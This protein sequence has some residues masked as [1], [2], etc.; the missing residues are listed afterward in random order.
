MNT[1][2]MNR[3]ILT[4]LAV[5]GS[6]MA[7]AQ[8]VHFSQM[9]Y[10]PLTLN[11]ALAGANSPL[12]VILNYR[13]QW[14]S[15]ASPYKTMAAS[16]DGRINDNKRGKK[17]N[18]AYGVNF[19]NDQAGDARV[20]TTNV[21]ATLGY[22]I[23][24]DRTSTLGAA[25]C[26]GFGQRS[27]DPNSGR[28]GSQY[29][30]MAYDPTL[31]SGETF[32]TDR[33]AFGDFGAGIVY[34]YK[35]GD[36][37]MT[38]NDQ[39]SFNY[40]FALYHINKPKYSYLGAAEEELYMRWSMFANGNIGLGNSRWSI[41]P[42]VYYQRQKKAQELLVGTYF[43]CRISEASR[44]T[45]NN[46]SAFFA[47]GL[48]YRNRD[49]MVAKGMFEWSDYSVGFAYDINVSSLTEV[50]RSRGGVEIFLRYNMSGGFGS[51][52]SRI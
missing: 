35:E 31:S 36:R 49:A 37:Y 17:G 6:Y 38:S 1:K 28:W 25:I 52:R 27:I 5:G 46:Q 41:M 24:L 44:V 23:I 34:T 47:L 4:L 51:S 22:H 13:T 7:S 12:Q 39:K 15:V 32:S 40:G 21:T 30:G 11:P 48:F 18:L 26:G 43:K 8:D 45:S 29:N 42:G 10:S 20:T 2:R 33:F 14:R 19:F 3:F 16:V 50:S 9:A